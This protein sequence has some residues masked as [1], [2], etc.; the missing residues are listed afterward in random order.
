MGLKIYYPAV[1]RGFTTVSE[2]HGN[3]FVGGL[4]QGL[5][6]MGKLCAKTDVA[7]PLESG[8]VSA[9]DVAGRSADGR[10]R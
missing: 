6:T 9:D 4:I 5:K 2:D 3:C 8:W 7:A 10:G 1:A